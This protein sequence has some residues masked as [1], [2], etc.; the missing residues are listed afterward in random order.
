[1]NTIVRVRVGERKHIWIDYN[2]YLVLKHW[3]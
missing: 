2:E 3:I 1:V